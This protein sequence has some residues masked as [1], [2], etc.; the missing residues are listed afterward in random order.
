MRDIATLLWPKTV[1][2]VGASNDL[3]GPR[4]RVLETILS[5]P[6]EGKVYPV[7]RSADVVQGLKAYKSVDDLPE[8]VDLA[9][10]I[11]PAQF[12]PAELEHCGKAGVKAAGKIKPVRSLGSGQVSVIS[13]S[14]SLGFVFSAF[15]EGDREM[16][17]ALKE[18]SQ[19]PV[20]L[21]TYTLP[22]ERSIEI[23]N[24]AAY[25]LFTGAPVAR[26]R[27][28]RSWTT[29]LC[30]NAAGS[31]PHRPTSMQARASK[32]ANCSPRAPMCC[33]NGRRGCRARTGG[34]DAA[35]LDRRLQ[36]RHQGD[37]EQRVPNFSGR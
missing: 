36:G 32:C 34:A 27:W 21:W 11:I 20:L 18:A 25:P 29:G 2:V 26:R 4:G 23:I 14:G 5:H 35:A 33:P 7:S 30:A 13:Q 3:H 15:L 12:V 6:Y 17:K 10:L 22:A 28:P 24:E 1:A 16:L 37:A 9:L 8:P 19:K 31:R